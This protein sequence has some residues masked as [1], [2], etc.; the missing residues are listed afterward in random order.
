LRVLQ[1]AGYPAPTEGLGSWEMEV[2]NAAGYLVKT[3]MYSLKYGEGRWKQAH[4]GIIGVRDP[5]A[6]H[7]IMQALLQERTAQYTAKPR[8]R[9]LKQSLQR[10]LIP[11]EFYVEDREITFL[12]D[13]RLEKRDD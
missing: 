8:P 2:T 7:A 9:R 13:D 3:K 5:E 11:G 10:G 4:H 12:D 6:L 1:R